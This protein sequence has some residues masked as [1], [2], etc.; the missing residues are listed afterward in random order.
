[1]LGTLF[2]H[3]QTNHGIWEPGSKSCF[4]SRHLVSV[5]SKTLSGGVQV[6]SA[7]P[8]PDAFISITSTM[9][10]LQ[11][12]GPVN[13]CWTYMPLVTHSWAGLLT[14]LHLSV[15]QYL[16]SA[17]PVCCFIFSPVVHDLTEPEIYL[18]KKKTPKVMHG[19]RVQ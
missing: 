16:C 2:K 10:E 15:H 14:A 3:W 13:Q 17:Q 7:S 18:V 1:M 6:L 9:D 5:Q 11:F 19:L 12:L 4:V 8:V